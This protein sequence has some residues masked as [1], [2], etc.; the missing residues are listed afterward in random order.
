MNKFFSRMTA[1]AFLA[2]L[3]GNVMAADYYLSAGGNDAN[4]GQSSAASVASLSKALTLLKNEGDV[5]HVS[6]I[7]K[8][9][10]Q[11]VLQ[12]KNVTIEGDGAGAGFEGENSSILKLSQSICTLKNLIFQNGKGTRPDNGQAAGALQ[13]YSSQTTIDGCSFENNQTIDETMNANANGGAIFVNGT[14]TGGLAKTFS[15]TVK[16]SKFLNNE[17]AAN[18]GAVSVFNIP[19]VFENCTFSGNKG[20]DGG[21]LYLAQVS[22]YTI[23]GC[24]FLNNV[25]Y[26]AK[27][28]SNQVA[29]GNGGA[30]KV[31]LRNVASTKEYLMSTTTFFGN[32]ATKTG[33]CYQVDVADNG[34]VAARTINFENCTLTGNSTVQ[35]RGSAINVYGGKGAVTISN[36]I[37]E[38]NVSAA[39]FADLYNGHNTLT[40]TVTI[41][42]SIVG[43]IPA[44]GDA[45][46][47]L[48]PA[49]D[50]YINKTAKLTDLMYAGLASL[51]DANVIPV[52]SGSLAATKGT[53]G[54]A[55]GATETTVD[56]ADGKMYVASLNDDGSVKEV[57]I[58]R[59]LVGGT[60]N[61]LCLPFSLNKT[62]KTEF[63]QNFG[64]GAKIACL[65]GG[66]VADGVI[67]FSDRSNYNNSDMVA[68]RAYIVMP[69][70][71]KDIKITKEATTENGYSTNTSSQVGS[72]TDHSEYK[73]IG[74]LN[75]TDL[76]TVN[77]NGQIVCL[78]ANGQFFTPEEGKT[79]IN[80]LRGYFIFPANVQASAMS[81]GGLDGTTG[82]NG[83]K[84]NVANKSAKIYT[85][86][87]QYMGTNAQNL[88]QGVYVIGNKKVVVK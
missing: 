75:P 72:P 70:A 34:D 6:G 50:S 17:S 19:V 65:S 30:I 27:T 59:H 80:G 57:T 84:A 73:F 54:K 24:S 21:A 64:E 41:K 69:T 22:S 2:M 1:M 52:I 62:D 44:Y 48:Y 51:N 25:S 49:T 10:E 78:G 15:L 42:N 68:A 35:G 20:L 53:D 40:S 13:I 47:S 46:A 56:N 36:S 12:S 43:S 8:V 71:D 86:S 61:T 32:T 14:N 26:D 67:T 74:V 11:G 29:G 45:V 79:T 28:P 81:L 58:C 60:W 9:S 76:S 23:K 39:A 4:D 16:N 77:A 55:I 66:K 38:G 18:G 83:V 5:L 3:S 31:N 82:I 88:P 85:L 37:L 87:G 63:A 33:A 7:I